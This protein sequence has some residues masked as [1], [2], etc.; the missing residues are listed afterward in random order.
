MVDAAALSRTSL[1]LL[2]FGLGLIFYSAFEG[3]VIPL[4]AAPRVGLSVHTL[5]GFQG[6]FLLAQGLMWPRLRLSARTSW[7]AFWLSIYATFAVLAAYSFAAASGAGLETI[8]IIGE[9]PHGLHHGDLLEED[10]V[11][12][13]AYSSAPAGLISYAIMAFGLRGTPNAKPAAV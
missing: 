9:L 6:V 10:V 1:F 12:V 4:L 3:F 11:R 8:R 7:I 2:R 5:A 13:L